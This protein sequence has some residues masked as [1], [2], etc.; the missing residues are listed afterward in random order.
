[1]QI[2]CERAKTSDRLRIATYRYRH[3]MFACSYIDSGSIAI[4][5]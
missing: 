3:I 5:Q 4:E 2:F 1:M